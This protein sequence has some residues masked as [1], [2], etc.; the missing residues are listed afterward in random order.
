MLLYVLSGVWNEFSVSCH[1][2]WSEKTG[3]VG[4]KKGKR[5]AILSGEVERD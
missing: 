2:M 3:A 1:I 4:I 5:R